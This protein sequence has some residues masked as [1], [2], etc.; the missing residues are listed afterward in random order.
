MNIGMPYIDGR[1]MIQNNIS[2][3]KEAGLFHDGAIR[4]IQHLDNEI[5]FSMESAQVLPEWNEDKIALSKR[6]TMSGKLFLEKIKN[7]KEDGRWF[8]DKFKIKN[9]YNTA[10]IYDFEIKLNKVFLCICWIKYL[11][12]YEESKVYNYEIEAEKIYW[13]N[14]PSLFDE[15]WE[16]YEENEINTGLAPLSI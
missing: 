6:D 1:K 15:Y 3:E 5:Q 2:I 13:K 11:P 9:S 8:S 14:I 16:C 7:V 10:R 4:E 12:Q